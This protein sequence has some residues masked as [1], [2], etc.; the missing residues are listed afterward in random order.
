MVRTQ[1]QITE[2]Q[3]LWLKRKASEANVSMADLIRQ[4]IDL[5][6]QADGS[7]SRAD[8][9]AR[10]RAASGKYRSEGSD[11]AARHDDHLA[12]AFGA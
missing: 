10:A 5:Y 4:G 11:G 7:V 1:I 8:R 3:S 2:Q 9:I 6:L 12:E